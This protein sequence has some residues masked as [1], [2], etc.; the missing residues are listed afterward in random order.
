MC[1]GSQNR[2][3][4]LSAAVSVERN[5]YRGKIIPNSLL[6][7]A[8]CTQILGT[9]EVNQKSQRRCFTQI[10]LLYCRADKISS[11]LMQHNR[12]CDRHSFLTTL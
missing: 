9:A 5:L 8:R 6:I 4:V 7:T 10:K 2:I 1:E 3:A 11:Y 12:N